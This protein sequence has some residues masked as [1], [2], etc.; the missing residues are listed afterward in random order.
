[1][2]TKHI[3]IFT[4]ALVVLIAAIGDG[5]VFAN[6]SDT[7]WSFVLSSANSSYQT[8]DFRT[9]DNSTSVYVRP[10]IM[11]GNLTMVY[12]KVYG[13]TDT[14][15]SGATDL[16]VRDTYYYTVVNHEYSM[17]NYV[18]ERGYSAAAF[19]ACSGGGNGTASGY[20]SPDTAG[21]IPEMPYH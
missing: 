4:T 9:K 5:K 1:M 11:G 10:M 19:A 14:N 18:K 15:G 21:N 16:T 20:W 7:Y 8:S 17:Q 6:T 3:I 12:A 2:K 13:A